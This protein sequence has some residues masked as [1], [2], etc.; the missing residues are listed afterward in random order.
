M[1]ITAFAKKVAK[2]EAKKREVNIAQ[3]ME[4]LCVI[5]KLTS[6][7]LYRIIRGI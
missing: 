1:K 6:G 4:I 5:N 7:E 2:L 3:I